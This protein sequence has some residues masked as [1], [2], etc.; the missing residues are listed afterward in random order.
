M[1]MPCRH[2][3]AIRNHLGKNLYDSELVIRRWK[4]SYFFENSNFLNNTL[5]D[6]NSVNDSSNPTVLIENVPKKNVYQRLAKK[7]IEKHL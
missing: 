1:G 5:F 3:F 6:N 4:I 2:I 7:D